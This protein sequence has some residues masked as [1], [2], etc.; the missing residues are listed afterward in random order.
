MKNV[1]TILWFICAFVTTN[2]QINLVKNGGFEQYSHC[3]YSADEVKFANYWQPIDSLGEVFLDST[4]HI[5]HVTTP[6]CTPEYCNACDTSTYLWRF[7]V[8]IGAAYYHYARSGHGMAQVQMYFDNSFSFAY[9]RDY[10]QGHFVDHL[11]AGTTYCVTLYTGL[12]QASQYAINHIGAYID[13]GSI[14]IAQDSDGCSLSQT[15]FIP[16]IISDSIIND[17]LHWVKIQG[18]YTATGNERFIT[19][20]NFSD[21]H[22]TDTIKRSLIY[23]PW[24]TENEFSWY[25]IDDVSVIPS[26]T[27]A[28]AGPDQWVSPG[29]DSAFIG[30]ADEGLPTTWYIVGDST[31]IC[32]G[33]GGFKVHPDTTTSYVVVLDLC[34]NLTKDTV[35][36]H[37]APAIINDIHDQPLQVSVFPNP[38]NEYLR[39][40]GA[41][42]CTYKIVNEVGQL[43][44]QSKITSNSEAINVSSLEAGIYFV[45]IESSLTRQKEISRF[46]KIN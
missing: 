20:G 27:F 29:S 35:T 3:P 14:D 11:V 24:N 18:S 25:L 43:M 13:N 39:I 34:D 22:H 1:V 2:A 38:A 37:V 12:E 33:A 7:S 4:G 10:L 31:P 40:S 17:T 45:Q 21:I 41:N 26:N 46:A 6:L 30:I 32:D 19:I 9:Q 36:I 23:P 28:N 16:Q 42:N 5:S 44:L 15:A 8:P